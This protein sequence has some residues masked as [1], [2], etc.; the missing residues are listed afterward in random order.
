MSSQFEISNCKIGFPTAK[1]ILFADTTLPR[2]STFT[3][4]RLFKR[5]ADIYIRDQTAVLKARATALKEAYPVKYAKV[6]VHKLCKALGWSAFKELPKTEQ[7]E[8]M[9]KVHYGRGLVAAVPDR[10]L[11][12]VRA[13]PRPLP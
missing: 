1:W 6:P 5:G 12:R 11:W 3:S 4:K 9:E 10:E 2:P 7:L 8:C 13:L